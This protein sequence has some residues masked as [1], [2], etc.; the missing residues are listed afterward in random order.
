MKVWNKF[1]ADLH[2]A[3]SFLE[4]KQVLIK[5]FYRMTKL[6][7]LICV[8]V[9]LSSGSMRDPESGKYQ[10]EILSVYSDHAEG[11]ATLMRKFCWM[12]K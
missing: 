9:F 11:L 5:L 8:G 2:L 6:A 12:Q 4:L 3:D 1:L 10:L 7:E